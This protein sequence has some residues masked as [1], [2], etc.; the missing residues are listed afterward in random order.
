M[1]IRLS[2][3]PIPSSRS[4]RTSSCDPD[5]QSR[6]SPG[7]GT[8]Y[9]INRN[10][11]LR[12]RRRR[13]R[14]KVRSHVEAERAREQGDPGAAQA[15]RLWA[16]DPKNGGGSVRQYGVRDRSRSSTKQQLLRY[17]AACL[18]QACLTLSAPIPQLILG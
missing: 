13:V 7:F 6:S 1:K 16:R 10:C 5:L 11:Q 3:P 12:C 8:D 4:N 17:C 18:I 2:P 15:E 14:A 9:F